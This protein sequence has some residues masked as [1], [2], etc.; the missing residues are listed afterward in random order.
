[1]KTLKISKKDKEWFTQ[2]R[3]ETFRKVFPSN[4]SIRLDET[5]QQSTRHRNNDL[6]EERRR[7][8]DYPK[9]TDTSVAMR[10]E[11]RS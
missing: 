2:P 4:I 7:I 1:M 8:L 9:W 11:T 3:G 5:F 10:S 6:G